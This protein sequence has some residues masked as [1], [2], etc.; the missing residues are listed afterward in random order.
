MC[1]LSFAVEV[2]IDFLIVQGVNLVW[3]PTR[4]AGHRITSIYVLDYGRHN[5]ETRCQ[6][7]CCAALDLH[8]AYTVA[9]GDF[10]LDGG[11]GYDM[12]KNMTDVKDLGSL[13]DFLMHY[14]DTSG[15]LQSSLLTCIMHY[16]LL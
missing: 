12:V 2:C 14:I 16:L 13:Q 10:L 4:P 8:R 5:C 7:H 6:G 1:I 3:D 9:V 15:E 11:D